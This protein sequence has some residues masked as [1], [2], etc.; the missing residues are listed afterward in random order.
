MGKKTPGMGFLS[1]PFGTDFNCFNWD[2]RKNKKLLFQE[3][4]LWGSSST[5]H[6]YK[7][8]IWA[9]LERRD[10]KILSVS[11]QVKL[12]RTDMSA[13]S[14]YSIQEELL[15]LTFTCDWSLVLLQQCPLTLKC[16]NAELLLYSLLAVA[17]SAISSPYE[18][19]HLKLSRLFLFLLVVVKK[20]SFTAADQHLHT[21][22]QV[23][24]ISPQISSGYGLMSVCIWI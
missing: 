8:N 17:S 19:D 6:R 10:W 21:H 13:Q 18:L 7:H 9:S 20:W 12:P 4:F 15:R 2:K 3:C 23:A 14:H 5:D 1:D 16:F 22:L 24:V 11:N